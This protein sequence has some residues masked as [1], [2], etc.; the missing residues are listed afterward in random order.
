MYYSM[1]YFVPNFSEITSFAGVII[2]LEHPAISLYQVGGSFREVHVLLFPWENPLVPLSFGELFYILISK[3]VDRENF[4]WSLFPDFPLFRFNFCHVFLFPWYISHQP[5][6]DP[7][8]V[9]MLFRT[10]PRTPGHT[11]FVRKYMVQSIEAVFQ[12]KLSYFQ[13]CILKNKLRRSFSRKQIKKIINIQNLRISFVP[14]QRDS[15]TAF[16]FRRDDFSSKCTI[17][18]PTSSF[19]GN[20][21]GSICWFVDFQSYFQHGLCIW[22]FT[23]CHLVSSLSHRGSKS[24]FLVVG[25]WHQEEGQEGFDSIRN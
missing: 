15:L 1:K 20:L 11:F 7:Q 8:V 18:S 13:L 23:S 2:C 9:R 6:N 14:D 12:K 24:V 4:T 21:I 22:P 17:A 16:Q 25:Q 19:R 5:L 10:W 3:P